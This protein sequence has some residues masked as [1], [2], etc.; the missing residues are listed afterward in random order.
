MMG[1]YALLVSSSTLETRNIDC[2]FPQFNTAAR[3]ENSEV[4][5]VFYTYLSLLFQYCLYWSSSV[6]SKQNTNW[7]VYLKT[8]CAIISGSQARTTQAK[9]NTKIHS[10]I[11]WPCLSS[12]FICIQIAIIPLLLRVCTKSTTS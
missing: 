12:S 2:G 1:L 5:Q 3:L 11:K 6:F 10:F 7:S 4:I 8:N 9:K